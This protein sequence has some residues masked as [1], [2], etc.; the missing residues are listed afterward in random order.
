MQQLHDGNPA[1]FWSTEH[2]A[3]RDFGHA[4]PGVGVWLE[5][6]NPAAVRTVAVDTQASGW[7]AD[8]FVADSPGTSLGAWGSAVATGSDLP[9]DAT[10]TI[11]K[12]RAA[13]YVLIWFTSLPPTDE[14][15]VFEVRLAS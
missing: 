1:T 15:H 6:A 11:T 14:L 5:L 7:S 9:A 2:Y 3:S 8:V 12:P 10:L 4:K 13:K